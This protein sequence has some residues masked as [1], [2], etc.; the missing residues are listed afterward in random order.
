MSGTQPHSVSFAGIVINDAGQVLMV[1]RHDNGHW[2]PPGG[3][4]ELDETFAQGVRREV[5]EETG[6]RVAV[7]PLTGVYKNMTRGIVAL[8]FRCTVDAGQARTSDEAAEVAWLEQSDALARM[9]PAYAVRV[10]DALPGS[11]I[12]HVRIHDGTYLVAP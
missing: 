7:G 3:V 1:K 6:I 5:L 10:V 11:A 4:L 2:E 9:T 12:P 8:V